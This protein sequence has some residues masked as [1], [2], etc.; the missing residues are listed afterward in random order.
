ML[1]L[2]RCCC[3]SFALAN[4]VARLSHWYSTAGVGGAGLLLLVVKAAPD[5]GLDVDDV[6]EESETEDI[7]IALLLSSPSF[8][9][10]TISGRFAGTWKLVL[11]VRLSRNRLDSRCAFDS[12]APSLLSAMLDD[13]DALRLLREL[14]DGDLR[15]MPKLSRWP[16][17]L[18]GLANLSWPAVVAL[19]CKDKLLGSS[20]LARAESPGD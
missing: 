17:G 5:L 8:S 6:C 19:V 16:W 14:R 2:L 18:V 9:E 13:T 15:N 3:R 20:D 1:L 7:C 11:G 10:T 12:T 4:I